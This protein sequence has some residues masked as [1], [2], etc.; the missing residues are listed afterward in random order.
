MIKIEV[1]YAAGCPHVAEALALV[2]RC[3]ARLAISA[4]LAVREADVPSP[5]VLVNGVDVMGAPDGE[6]A[7]CRLDRPTE[8]RVLRALAE[9][10]S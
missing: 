3:L 8:V 2:E 6:A 9:A 7:L 4:E 10:L 5:S 1:L